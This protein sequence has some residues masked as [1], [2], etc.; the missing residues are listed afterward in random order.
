[1][2][3]LSYFLG[4]LFAIFAGFIIN[5]GVLL[6]KKIINKNKNELKF[7]VSLVK[8]PLWIFGILL[9]I[10]IGGLIFY[11]I[12]IIFIGPALVPGLMASGLI[13]LSLGSVKLLNEKVEKKEIIGTGLMIIGI[14]LLGLN[15]LTIHVSSFNMLDNSFLI[16]LQFLSLFFY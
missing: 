15:Q 5:I 3:N 10:V 1:M 13:I 7:M 9:Q 2:S 16:G 4:V 8:N 11:L 12:A 14:F 6:Q